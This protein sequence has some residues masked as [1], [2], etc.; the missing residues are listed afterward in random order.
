[1]N[2]KDWALAQ[3]IH[4]QTAYKMF[5]DGTLPVPA[6]RVGPRLILVNPEAVTS[7]P[8]EGVGLYARV[9]SH[10]QKDD[11][12]RQTARLTAWAAQAGHRV[13]RSE[14]EVGS[15]MNGARAKARRVLSDPEVTVVVV[16]HRDR[17]GRMNTEL[18]EAALSA[19]G[20]RLVV[21]DDG[22]VEDDLVRDI[23]EVLTS[24]CA[25]LYGR[26]SAKNRAKRALECAAGSDGGQ[27]A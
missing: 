25:R 13:I 23:T 8:G 10:D 18:V 21:L 26:R 16:E 2:L 14:A 4:P 15:G 20:R 19:S 17:L 9:S 24:F 22:E 11:L 6:Q 27:S 3:G 5:R 12:A 7:S 1:M